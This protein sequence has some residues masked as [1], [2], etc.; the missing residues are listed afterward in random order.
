M[1][2]TEARKQGRETKRLE[3][4][5][6]KELVRLER[7]N[8]RLEKGRQKEHEQQER[9]SR[10]DMSDAIKFL[11][12]D[13]CMKHM[14]ICVDT[15]ILEDGGSDVLLETLSS[16]DCR[17]F[18][19][20][21][22]VTCS[23]TWRREMPQG[24]SGLSG[25]EV[26]DGE[27]EE[28]LVLVEPENFLKSVYSL[29]KGSKEA[30]AVTQSFA[31]DV[32]DR[33]QEKKICLI[34]IGLEPYR[35]YIRQSQ[36]T[37]DRTSKG[38]SRTQRSP[39]HSVTRRQ[40]QE[41]LVVLQLWSHTDVLFLDTWLEFAQHVGAVTKAIAQRPFKKRFENQ[42]FSFCTTE[43]RWTS[44]VRVEKDGKGLRQAWKRQIQQFN[45][46]SPSMAATVTAAYPSP[47]LLLQAYEGC[48]TEKEKLN[49]LTGLTVKKE[50]YSGRKG[51]Q[52]L[53]SQVKESRGADNR[54]MEDHRSPVKLEGQG[55]HSLQEGNSQ[56]KVEIPEPN[57]LKKEVSQ[58]SESLGKQE[59]QAADSLGQKSEVLLRLAL[60]DSE[61]PGTL[62]KK[63]SQD[64]YTPKKQGSQSSD[65]V[66]KEESLCAKITQKLKKQDA[67]SLMRE[68]S[69]CPEHLVKDDLSSQ[70]PRTESF[71]SADCKS[72]DC[73]G[74]D[75]FSTS[76]NIGRARRLG[77]DL[78][79]RVY[80][81][82]C[83]TNPDLVLDIGS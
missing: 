81:F 74:L 41:A 65:T 82:M 19:E 83:A 67:S 24:W 75:P 25:L 73:R 3:I 70:N 36:Q 44:G 50:K 66:K 18:I 80:I 16:L 9:Q 8:K 45:R 22:P 72:A 56:E 79:R 46:V 40:I 78:S 12:P 32:A 63:K 39:E 33:H 30:S 26:K 51:T 2:Q 28:M 43:G 35:S 62:N 10:K 21:Q 27:E 55:K 15:G 29:R 11:R 48:S 54:A 42:A 58:S 17:Y 7:E 37:G 60:G 13:Q 34:V 52:D 5:Q 1:V 6:A 20:P 23:I 4:K 57:S 76:E 61:A 59:S 53:E 68:N 49:L 69:Q 38:D 14:S 77:P 71:P 64:T 47:N 31:F